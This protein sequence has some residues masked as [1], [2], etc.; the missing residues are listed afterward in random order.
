VVGKPDGKRLLGRARL[1]C[2]DN[3]KIVIKTNTMG[4]CGLD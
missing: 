2:E 4:G 3:I 1:R